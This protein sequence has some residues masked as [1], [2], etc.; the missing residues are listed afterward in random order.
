[1][2]NC[3][4]GFLSCLKG[5]DMFPVSTNLRYEGETS[6]KTWIGFVGT[7]GFYS[8]FLWAVITIGRSVLSKSDPSVQTQEEN[9]QWPS[10]MT[11]YPDSFP[12]ILGLE[13]KNPAVFYINESIYLPKVEEK[14]RDQMGNRSVRTLKV[15]P[16]DPTRHGIKGNSRDYFQSV[17]NSSKLYCVDEPTSISGDFSADNFTYIRIGFGVCVNSTE[18]GNS[19]APDEDI[20]AALKTGYVSIYFPTYNKDFSN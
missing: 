9:A 14:F 18:N 7:L 4:R 20:K 2:A 12:L 6:Y 5:Y 16:C 19:C 10:N 13:A 15:V 3:I 17:I 8:V 11:F 1:M